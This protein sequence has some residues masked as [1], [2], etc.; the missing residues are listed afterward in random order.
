[1]LLII[2]IMIGYITSSAISLLN[3]FSTAEGV[4]SYMI[5]GMGNFGGV[6]LQ[7]LPFFLL[8]HSGG[9]ADYHTADKASECP[10]AGNTLCRKP[11]NQHP[12]YT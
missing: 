3:F 1:M 12:P 6:S 4:H 9:T 11:G 7:Q 10:A 2:G 8:G 5:W